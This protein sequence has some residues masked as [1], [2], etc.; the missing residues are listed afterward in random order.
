VRAYAAWCE[1]AQEIDIAVIR[2]AMDGAGERFGTGFGTRHGRARPK[3]SK[4]LN[5]R[6]ERD[7][8][9]IQGPSRISKLVIQKSDP[10][11]ADPRKSP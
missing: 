2:R 8:N 1:G 5:W 3:C 6:R 4:G 9:R 10:V 7:S 11:P